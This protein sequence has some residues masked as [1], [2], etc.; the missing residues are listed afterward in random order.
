L[1][2]AKGQVIV[3]HFPRR[4]RSGGDK[5]SSTIVVVLGA[6]AQRVR[7]GRYR[8]ATDLAR[9]DR[10][11]AQGDE[12]PSPFGYYWWNQNHYPW[13]NAAL[14]VIFSGIYADSELNYFL[15][16]NTN[17]AVGVGLNGGHEIAFALEKKF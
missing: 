14:R 8:I 13:T 17:V 16:A 2:R 10:F 1:L 6:G 7:A 5:E 12:Q 11:R 15:P 9:R 4:N 3:R